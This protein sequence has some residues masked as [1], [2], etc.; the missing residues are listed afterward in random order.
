[1]TRD[2]RERLSLFAG[3]PVNV[4]RIALNID[5]VRE[6]EPHP[7]PLKRDGAGKLTDSRAK[8]FRDEF[9]DE[10]FELDSLTSTQIQHIIEKNVLMVRDKAKWDAAVDQEVEHKRYIRDLMDELGLESSAKDEDEDD[11][12]DDD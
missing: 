5:Q 11:A 4:Q 6:F 7:N 9:G 1:M 3:F 2:N 8:D 10:S 12:G